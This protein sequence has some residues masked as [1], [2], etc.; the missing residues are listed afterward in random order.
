MDPISAL[1]NL[2]AEITKL[3]TVIVQSQPPDVQKQMWDW[4]VT[5]IKAWRQLFHLDGKEP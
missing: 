2:V 3:V 4:Y 1:A 5:D